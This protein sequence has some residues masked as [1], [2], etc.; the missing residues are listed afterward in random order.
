MTKPTISSVNAV[1]MYSL[2]LEAFT[3]VSNWA[4]K[5]LILQKVR[6]SQEPSPLRKTAQKTIAT[7]VFNIETPQHLFILH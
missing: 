4:Y 6:D 2:P 5:L 7:L 3:I 1:A